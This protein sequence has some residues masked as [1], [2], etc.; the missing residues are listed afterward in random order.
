MGLDLP[1]PILSLENRQVLGEFGLLPCLVFCGQARELKGEG[2]AGWPV[3]LP[4]WARDGVTP[5][6]LRGALCL[7]RVLRWHNLANCPI[8]S[9]NILEDVIFHLK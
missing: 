7:V 1:A 8:T 9:A 6:Y 2:A 3:L 5:A 4:G